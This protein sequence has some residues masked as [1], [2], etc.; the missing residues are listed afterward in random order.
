MPGKI[1]GKC[2]LSNSRRVRLEESCGASWELCPP[3]LNSDDG[4]D[5]VHRAT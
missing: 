3:S 5:P 1:T 2:L 4:G